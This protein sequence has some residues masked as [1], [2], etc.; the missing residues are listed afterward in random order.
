MSKPRVVVTIEG[1]IASTRLP[2]K[3]LYPLAGLPMM[4]QIVRRVKRA[5]SVDDVV[6]A[7]T[8]SPADRVVA[9]LGERIGCTVHRGPVKDISQRLLGAAGSADI[10][11][12]ITGDCPLVDPGLIDH[13]VALLQC[14]GA[15]YVSNS[16]SE[17]TYPIGFDVRAFTTEAL[18]ESMALSDD[19]IDRVHGSYFIARRPDLFRHAS[20]DAPQHL[21]YPGLR[22]TVDEP[23]DYA[24][25]HKIYEA[26][27]PENQ[28]FD[29]EA[30]IGLI[31]R[32]PD[33]ALIN[34][35]VQ[36][37]QASEG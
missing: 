27:Y 8:D 14:S 35:D 11:V 16:L 32:H 30:V 29:V 13:A 2:G 1:R 4:E 23:A 28:A 24:L 6:I 17:C 31:R 21:R 37:K 22:L 34:A 25:V 18:R 19:P 9:D 36:Q 26:L 7:T 5:A 20:W 33:W 3:I 10:I 12:Q 15:D